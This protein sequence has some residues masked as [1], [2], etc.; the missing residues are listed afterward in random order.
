[1]SDLLYWTLRLEEYPS[2]EKLA[3]Y[4]AYRPHVNGGR[5]VIRSHQNLGRSVKF[6]L[7]KLI[8]VK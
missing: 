7:R 5:I 2:A 6:A 3:E 1:M 8:V 4:A